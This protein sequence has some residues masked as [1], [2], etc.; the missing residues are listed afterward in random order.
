MKLTNLQLQN[1][2]NYESVQLEFTDGVH[3]LLVKMHRVKTNLME[4][5][6][7]FGDDK[8]PPYH[9]RQRTDWMEKDFAT[10]KGTVEK[11]A[12]KTNLELQFLKKEKSRK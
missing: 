7:A 12:T 2:R 8:E 11:T 9:K 4:S 1:F 3:V 10:I 6:Y 5:I